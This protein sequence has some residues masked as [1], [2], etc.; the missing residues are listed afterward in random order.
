M[1]RTLVTSEYLSNVVRD[2]FFSLKK[3]HKFAQLMTS[4][5]PMKHWFT[6]LPSFYHFD[7]VF[8]HHY[9]FTSMLSIHIEDFRF[10][11]PKNE[12]MREGT[13]MNKLVSLFTLINMSAKEPGHLQHM[14]TLDMVQYF[15]EDEYAKKDRRQYPKMNEVAYKSLFGLMFF[16]FG[17]IGLIGI[18][19]L[20]LSITVANLYALFVTI[21]VGMAYIIVKCY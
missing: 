3:R 13:I 11:I 21:M 12:A 18:I 19:S 9:N 2:F 7:K 1:A 15:L 6:S 14:F 4:C 20:L 10:L 5:N 17:L 8:K 16:T